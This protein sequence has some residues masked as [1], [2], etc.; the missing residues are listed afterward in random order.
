MTAGR[1]RKPTKMHIYNGTDRPCR[2]NENEPQP[3]SPD[4][5]QDPPEYLPERAKEEWYRMGKILHEAGLLTV[6]D[7]TEFR[8][9]CLAESHIVEAE[10]KMGSEFVTIGAKG[11]EIQNPLMA[12]INK[13]MELSHKFLV[14][15]GMTPSSR[16]KIK[17]GDTGKKQNKFSVNGKR[18]QAS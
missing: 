17:V 5:L 8:N 4:E 12:I 6:L 14:E 2:R 18:Q 15:Y 10:K 13:S 1:P 11:T 16:T 7:Y 9:Y 3:D